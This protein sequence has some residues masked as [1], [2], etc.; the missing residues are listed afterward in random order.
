[1]TN[2]YLK[3]KVFLVMTVM[4]VKVLKTNALSLETKDEKNMTHQ[5]IW[6]DWA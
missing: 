6:G 4:V 1:M 3:K 2:V 5:Y